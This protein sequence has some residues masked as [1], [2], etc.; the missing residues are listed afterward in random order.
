M[1]LRLFESWRA[2][3][4]SR[5]KYPILSPNLSSI[6]QSSCTHWMDYTF[7]CG[8]ENGLAGGRKLCTTAPSRSH[9]P[10]LHSG[11]RQDR[12]RRGLAASQNACPSGGGTKVEVADGAGNKSVRRCNQG[13]GQGITR[14]NGCH[15]LTQLGLQCQRNNQEHIFE[16]W[17]R[18]WDPWTGHKR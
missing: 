7:R 18:G 15:G 5:S 3:A 1:S 8:H 12:C 11:K 6:I 2:R 17:V 4:S 9:S 16:L 13:S 14:K 10:P